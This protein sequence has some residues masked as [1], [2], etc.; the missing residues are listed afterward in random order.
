M[1]KEYKNKLKKL[2]ANKP[3]IVLILVV[4]A[5]LAGGL[6]LSLRSCG[7]GNPDITEA[8]V[9]YQCPMH[10]QIIQ[11]H[12]GTCPICHMDLTKVVDDKSVSKAQKGRKIV[13]YRN[14]MDPSK[15]SDKPLKDSMGM[16]YIPI[17]SDE[18]GDIMEIG[19][20]TGRAPFM[21]S[22]R[23][24]QLIGVKWITAERRNLSRRLR[25][26]GRVIGPNSV[27]AE[28]LEI[29]AG[30][31]RSGMKA[32]ITGPQEQAIDAVVSAVDPGFDAVTRSYSVALETRSEAGWLK[33][34][35]YCEVAVFIEY[36]ERMA[37]PADA[38]L[39]GGEHRIVF[40]TDTKGRFKPVEVRLGKAGEDWVEVLSGIKEGDRVV[41]SANFLIDSESQ[42]KAALEQF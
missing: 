9:M 27:A 8:G 24:Q 22:E 36:G 21:L 25:L 20:E 28:L 1:K 11:G 31:V 39:Y 7:N 10:P 19:R 2:M 38:V 4:A 26:P 17:Y 16:D 33:P 13:R 23:K 35:V 30:T 34:G 42:F 6:V 37:V 18:S 32:R 5:F 15:Y 40:V 29:D 14:P 12:P 41:T 3:A